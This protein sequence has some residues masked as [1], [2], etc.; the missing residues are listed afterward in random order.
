[1]TNNPTHEKFNE[2]LKLYSKEERGLKKPNYELK[3]VTTSIKSSN[4][5]RLIDIIGYDRR[6]TL[7][8]ELE[9]SINLYYDLYNISGKHG[10][11]L[12]TFVQS[13]FEEIKCIKLQVLEIRNDDDNVYTKITM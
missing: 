6:K 13:A 8:S 2:S 12:I 4:K 3:R 11:S 5:N 1:M 9:H 10:E 7:I